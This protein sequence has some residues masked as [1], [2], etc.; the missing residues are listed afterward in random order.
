MP[1]LL[2]SYLYVKDIINLYHVSKIYRQT[3]LK[4]FSQI[5][6]ISTGFCSADQWHS[7]I[8]KF[9]YYLIEDLLC[10]ECFDENF[11]NYFDFDE[12]YSGLL[13][14]FWHLSLFSVFLHFLTCIKSC[15]NMWNIPVYCKLCSRV[16]DHTFVSCNCYGKLLITFGSSELDLT[17]DHRIDLD[18]FLSNA[19]VNLRS[20]TKDN[21]KCCFFQLFEYAEDV[22]CAFSSILL[23]VYLNITYVTKKLLKLLLSMVI[24]YFRNFGMKLTLTIFMNSLICLT[25]LI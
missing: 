10:Q 24:F 17:T 9:C 21:G 5:Y 19:D 3:I 6:N 23:R 4:R 12:N 25:Q 8:Q 2:I 22:F 18:V 7:L 15:E 16:P 20:Y 1:N 11:L 14:E 13:K